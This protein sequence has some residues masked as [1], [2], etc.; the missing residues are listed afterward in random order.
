MPV[1]ILY[2]GI[3]HGTEIVSGPPTAPLSF[4]K[5]ELSGHSPFS[6]SRLSVTLIFFMSTVPWNHLRSPN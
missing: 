5:V 6:I 1:A 2:T 4:G 3:V